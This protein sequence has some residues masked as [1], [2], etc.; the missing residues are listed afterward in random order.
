MIGQEVTLVAA[1]GDL[2]NLERTLTSKLLRTP[3]TASRTLDS[4][5]LHTWDGAMFFLSRMLG[6]Y[7]HAQQGAAQVTTAQT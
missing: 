4:M 6:R 7:T 1:S 3:P 5:R 2:S